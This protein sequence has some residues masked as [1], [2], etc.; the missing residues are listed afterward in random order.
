MSRVR[1]IFVF[2]GLPL[3]V[4]FAAVI[5]WS[6]QSNNPTPD[7]QTATPKLTFE[8]TYTGLTG[9]T[10]IASIPD[11]AR[12]YIAEQAGVIRTAQN[13]K[14]AAPAFIDISERVL[15]KG[16]LG[17]LG[18]AFH[19]DLADDRRIFLNYTNKDRE[20]VVSSFSV[21]ANSLTADPR[22]EKKL[23]SYAQPFE[24]HNGGDLH[25]GQDG[26]LYIA[27]GDGG[28]GGDPGNR[29][30][31]LGNLLG[32]ILRLDIDSGSPYAIPA[33]NPFVKTAGARGEI[34]S[35]GLRNPWRFSFDRQTGDMWLGDVGQNKWE[36]IN[37]IPAGS[38]GGINFGW[39]CF[40]ATHQYN[41]TSC[42]EANTYQNPLIE[43]SHSDGGC[44]VT[45]GY[46]YGG[47]KYPVLSR[48]YLYADYCSGKISAG[49]LLDGQWQEITSH[50]SD[51]KITTFGQ[52]GL[53]E[54]YVADAASGSIYKI[55]AE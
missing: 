15:A 8:K 13:G 46:V 32:K 19:P 52:D 33:D 40:E 25:F 48:T 47:N 22:S 24:N 34:W 43:Y 38:K 49:K 54:I 28:S 12:I 5:A 41:P 18:V 4:V 11:S 10:A 1:G 6:F 21:A 39:R 36:E 26:Y 42:K 44:S 29:A 20:T 53:G 9:P 55:G 7:P 17:L 2:I 23:I 45:G 30:Q 14:V 27:S 50:E 16:E 51:W 3:L 35:Y 31:D 37:Y